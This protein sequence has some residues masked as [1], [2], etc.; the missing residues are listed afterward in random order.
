MINFPIKTILVYPIL[1]VI[2]AFSSVTTSAAVVSG[3]NSWNRVA[4]IPAGEIQYYIADGDYDTDSF[5][6][7]LC[8]TAG[9]PAYTSALNYLPGVS[10]E[11]PAVDGAC[12]THRYFF[13]W[14]YQH[15]K[16]NPAN[17]VFLGCYGTSSTYCVDSVW[18]CKQQAE[19]SLPGVDCSN[20]NDTNYDT[21]PL[22]EP[23]FNIVFG[24]SR[25]MNSFY[26]GS[27][28][29]YAYC[30]LNYDIIGSPYKKSFVC[31]SDY[32][33]YVIRPLEGTVSN[34]TLVVTGT[35][36]Q[37]FY[38][39]PNILTSSM[40][41]W[42]STNSSDNARVPGAF[43]IKEK[44]GYDDLRISSFNQ[45]GS[46]MA[47]TLKKIG[48]GSFIMFYDYIN[49]EQSIYY[50]ETTTGEITGSGY[51]YWDLQ[52]SPAFPNHPDFNNFFFD[53][54]KSIIS[55]KDVFLFSGAGSDPSAFS[56]STALTFIRFREDSFENSI[57]SDFNWASVSLFIIGIFVL[58]LLMY[59]GRF[60]LS[61]IRRFF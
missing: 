16:N 10:V 59:F 4:G 8:A 17:F 40:G 43:Y 50:V 60:L 56:H 23:F 30:G 31:A 29:S 26:K 54:N 27:D 28:D 7:Y 34:E 41:H 22:S 5:A 51:K 38:R 42:K 9:D 44:S 37:Y 25:A 3:W 39:S 21:Y 57:P 33:Q 6:A 52:L 49:G 55:G 36:P 53:N 46:V 61:T 15:D 48:P 12:M 45:E 47:P 2:L 35:N 18:D 13:G 14:A 11:F 32:G 24:D 1:I 20:L 58:F 19:E